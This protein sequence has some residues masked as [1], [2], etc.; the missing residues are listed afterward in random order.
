MRPIMA[1]G[2][3]GYHHHQ[4]SDVIVTCVCWRLSWFDLR[5]ATFSKPTTASLSFSSSSAV[6]VVSRK[7]CRQA[8]PKRQLWAFERKTDTLRTSEIDAF[9]KWKGKVNDDH[10]S[11][12]GIE[13]HPYSTNAVICL[14]CYFTC[15]FRAVAVQDKRR[16]SGTIR[17]NESNKICSKLS[18]SPKRHKGNFEKGQNWNLWALVRSLWEKTYHV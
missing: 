18:L 10:T 1:N 3:P 4:V 2:F 14:S 7:P 11:N 9:K 5:K 17:S 6:A 15:T 13:W 8:K 12:T 16:L